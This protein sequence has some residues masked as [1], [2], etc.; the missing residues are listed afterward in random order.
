[1]TDVKEGYRAGDHWRICDE[2][3]WK[4]RASETRKRWDGLIVC[5]PDFEMRHPQDFVRG[6]ADRQRVASP[7]PD[8]T[9]AYISPGDVTA[10]DL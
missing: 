6:R 8:P 2:C 7:R 9:P 5:L 10:D 3:G 1:M 4:V